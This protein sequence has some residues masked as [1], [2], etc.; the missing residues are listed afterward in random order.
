MEGATSSQERATSRLTEVTRVI[1]ILCALCV[2]VVT[3]VATWDIKF[4]TPYIDS[5]Q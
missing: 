4:N 1:H 5:H 3:K 2:S